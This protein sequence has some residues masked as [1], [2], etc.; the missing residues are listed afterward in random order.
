MKIRDKKGS[1]NVLADHLFL[2]E[3]EKANDNSKE[4]EETF[5]DE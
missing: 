3:N 5:P 2:F 1:E 4:I